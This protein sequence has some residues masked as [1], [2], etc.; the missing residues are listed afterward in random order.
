LKLPHYTHKVIAILLSLTIFFVLYEKVDFVKLKEVFIKVNSFDI[1]LIFLTFTLIYILGAYRWKV[2]S[3]VYYRLSFFESLNMI[4]ASSPLNV[5][6]P[7][8]MGS[9]AKAY[10]MTRNGYVRNKPALSM[11]IYEKLSDLAAMSVI[12]IIAVIL[13]YSFDFLIVLTFIFALF[14]ICVYTALHKINI[15]NTIFIQ[16]L[17]RVKII[18]NILKYAEVIY[19]FNTNPHLSQKVLLHINLISL[20]LWFVHIVQIVLFFHLL[21]LNVPVFAIVAYMLCAIFIGILPISLAG[22]GTRDLSIVYLFKGIISYNE[23]LAIGIL[24]TLR[25]VIPSLVGLP[26]FIH[27]MCLKVEKT[28][29]CRNSILDS[30]EL[31]KQ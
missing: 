27:L 22:I 24:S 14:F 8:K 9:F 11:V 31:D 20:M 21:M 2:I 26:F 1:F 3:N 28:D 4:A 23:A 16:R 17:K 15:F 12:F 18:G 25:Y 13:N 30:I 29:F 6:L 7:S 19:N 5:I 10:F